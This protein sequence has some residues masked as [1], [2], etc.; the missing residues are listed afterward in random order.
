MVIER[1]V[2]VPAD[3][4]VVL[5]ADV[6]RPEGPGRYPVIL[7]YGPYAKGL[8]FQEGY[9]DQWRLMTARAPGRGPRVEQRPPELGGRGPGEVGAGR[10]L[11]R[12]G[13]L[14]RGGPL[15]GPAS[16]PSRRGRPGTCTSASSGRRRSRGAP[17]R[18]GLNGISYYAMNQWHVAALHPPHLAAMCVWEGAADFYRD[19]TYHGGILLLV[20]ANWYGKQV[21]VVQHGV[22][23]RGPRHPVTGEPVAGPETL[24][25]AELAA[26][27]V[28]FGEQIRSHPLDDELPPGQVGGLGADHRPVA[29]RGQLGR[30]GPAH[31]RQLR[32]VHPGRGAAQVAG[33][34]RPGALDPLLHRLRGGPAETVLRLLPARRRQRLAGPAAGPAAGP[35]AGRV[36]PA[37]RAGMAAGPHRLAAALPAAGLAAS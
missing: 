28:P 20:L 15:A 35:P 7:T 5:R 26:A 9:A 4:G 11:L 12:P 22:G 19:A 2:P 34:A 18:S 25:D 1:D 8:A 27:R 29:D 6:F 32:G 30:A 10:L 23:E 17:A 24:T 14:A 21:T 31:P 3:D 16:T 36:H 33:G 13:G 37:G